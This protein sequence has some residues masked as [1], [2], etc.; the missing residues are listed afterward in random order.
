M[1]GL[2]DSIVA[3]QRLR[4][5]AMTGPALCKQPTGNQPGTFVT[6]AL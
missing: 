1:G 3:L 6:H 4:H 5:L 2:V